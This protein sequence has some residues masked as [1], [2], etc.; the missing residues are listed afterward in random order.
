VQKEYSFAVPPNLCY[1]NAG[2]NMQSPLALW[3]FGIW[4]AINAIVLLIS[5]ELSSHSGK[6]LRV[7]TNSLR[8]AGEI[9]GTLFMIV[10][11]AQA[12]YLLRT[13]LI[14]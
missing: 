4:L 11:A 8:K 14:R 13:G 1:V 7:R 12:Y 3:D 2:A 9:L 10:V 5:G 6:S